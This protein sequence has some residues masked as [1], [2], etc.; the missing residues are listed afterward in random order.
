MWD[1]SYSTSDARVALKQSSYRRSIF[2][3]HKDS[4]AASIILKTFLDHH[5]H[6]FMFPNE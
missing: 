1:E 4:V 5:E 2:L 6:D 3:K